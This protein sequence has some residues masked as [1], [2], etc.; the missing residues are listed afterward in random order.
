[1]VKKTHAAFAQV[2]DFFEAIDDRL[3]YISS[4]DTTFKDK[5]LVKSALVSIYTAI[6]EFWF[7][8]V[9]HYRYKF[10]SMLQSLSIIH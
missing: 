1:M 9:K 4:L 3:Q 10:K 5:Q 7:F 6:V 8:A 2:I